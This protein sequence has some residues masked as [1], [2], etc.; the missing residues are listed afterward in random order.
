[1]GAH[2]GIDEANA[3][4]GSTDRAALEGE[5]QARDSKDLQQRGDASAGPS[6]GDARSTPDSDE[7]RL[8]YSDDDDT[9]LHACSPSVASA[10]CVEGGQKKG[11]GDGGEADIVT[12]PLRVSEPRPRTAGPWDVGSDKAGGARM[13][14]SSCRVGG[15]SLDGG[16]VDV[17]VTGWQSVEAGGVRGRV[18]DSE[19]EVRGS[20]VTISSDSCVTMQST[21]RIDSVAGEEGGGAVQRGVN[22]VPT[23]SEGDLRAGSRKQDAAFPGEDLAVMRGGL[24]KGLPPVSRSLDAGS[25]VGKRETVGNGGM[26]EKKEI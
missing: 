17:D 20:L 25:V 19:Y 13:G 22:G 18:C 8:M 5:G 21:P 26:R 15:R 6:H 11:V 7:E 10:Q 16:A 1:M 23:G 4:G 2:L 24:R 9:D 3:G 14:G 12:R